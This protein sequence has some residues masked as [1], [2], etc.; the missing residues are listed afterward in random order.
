MNVVYQQIKLF[1]FKGVGVIADVTMAA[2]MKEQLPFFHVF[3]ASMKR[4]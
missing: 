4:L 1:T 2:S 3:Q